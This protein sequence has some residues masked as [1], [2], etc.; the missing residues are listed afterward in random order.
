M[1]KSNEI[2][3]LLIRTGQTLWEQSGR[4]VGSADVPLSD[5]GTQTAGQSAAELSEVKLATIYCGPDEASTATAKELAKATGA[6]VK[7][8]EGL[9]EV[10]L[11]LWEGMLEKVLEEKCPTAYR[12]WIEDPAA[13]Q[14]PEGESLEEARD[15]IMEALYRTLE[16]VKTDNGATGVVLRPFALALVGCELSGAPTRSL[17][18]MMKTGPVLQWR[19]FQRELLK[20]TLQLGRQQARTGT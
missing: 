13:V 10:H 14:V 17:W 4:I 9:S 1:G 2:R 15:R 8:V 6:K 19:T 12:Q 20:Q 3:V 7:T 16:K 11:G 5:A 18:S